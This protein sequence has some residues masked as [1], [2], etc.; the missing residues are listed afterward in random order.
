M[1]ELT[2]V[3]QKIKEEVSEEKWR[4]RILACQNSGLPVSLWCRENHIAPGS[5]YRHLRKLRENLIEENQIVPITSP[6]PQT[7]A[8]SVKEIQITMG[9][10]KITLPETASEKQL[11]AILQVLKSC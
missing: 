1:T 2:P 4:E 3:I 6:T 8:R 5:Y 11:R 10:M 9:E 7:N